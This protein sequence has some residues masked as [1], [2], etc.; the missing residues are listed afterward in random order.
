MNKR[1][2]SIGLLAALS[3]SMLSGCSLTGEKVENIPLQPALS[4]KEV[5]DYYKQSLAYDTV[6]SRTTKTNQVTYEM[7]EVTGPAKTMI[8][9]EANKIEAILSRNATDA[10]GVVSPSIHQYMKFVLDDKQLSGSKV[11][12]VNEALG[13]YFVDMEYKLSAKAPGAFNENVK[14]LGI[15]GAFK[16]D[17]QGALTVD[18]LFMEKAAGEVTEYLKENPTYK[19]DKSPVPG[20]RA[21]LSDVELYNKAA[22]MSLTQTAVMP[23][24][25]FVYQY[26]AE[27]L[28][29]YCLYPE[30]NFTLKD[31]GYSR[32]QLSGT[33]SIRYVFKK[34]IIDPTKI[35]FTNVYL[36]NY[37]LANGP[38]IDEAAIIPEFVKTEADKILERS[39]RAIS[40]N[41]VSALFTGNIYDDIGVGALYSNMSNYCY[42][43]RHMSKITSI[44][45][46][47]GHEYLV[48]FE[49]LTQESPKGAGTNG[50]YVSTGYM[51]VQQ[52]TTEFHI[53]DYVVTKKVMT[54]EPQ[55]SLESTIMK[56]LAALNLTG[57]V[58]EESRTGIK[59]MMQK[60][61]TASTER[62]LQDMYDC[63]D[64]DT[65]LLSS[66]HREY[67]NSQLRG[68]L[69]KFG[70]DTKS[71]YMGV[72]SQWIGGADNQVEFFTQ[73]LIDYT[74]RDSGQYM[75]NYYLVS[76]YEDKWV[77]DEMKVV[78]SKVV[79]GSE[80]TALRESIGSGKTVAV[81]VGETDRKDTNSTQ[82]GGYA[83]VT[84]SP[85][86][87]T[88]SNTPE[89]D[90][91]DTTTP[92]GETTPGE[93]TTPP[94]GETTE[95]VGETTEPAGGNWA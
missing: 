48:G 79:T 88:N 76:R 9:S 92:D 57:E 5:I 20:V 52:E 35:E 74:D 71:T 21:P 30:G 83:E 85:T 66:T 38:K 8:I 42:N 67:L 94:A 46:R 59:E 64:T 1:M 60:L 75:Q 6:T 47:N 26:P 27:G 87:D 23:E 58:S 43:Q 31:F 2:A 41:D 37:E 25:A 73:E 34:D 36:L 69:L 12:A 14:Y 70:T 4:Q 19:T 56:R 63:F 10:G 55:I 68:W 3:V 24:L 62:Q 51:V 82:S 11:A 80:L 45:G 40:N 16:M 61:Y 89:D 39:D 54:K 7:Q 53:T 95:P 90:T 22:G 81:D 44:V 18:T 13:Y 15:N 49:T 77:I 32:S 93:E 28:S 86:P 50:T 17:A 78:E 33:A 29:G 84:P 65:N 91:T 72:I